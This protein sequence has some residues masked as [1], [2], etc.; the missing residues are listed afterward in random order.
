MEYL[1]K[2][3]FEK[4]HKCGKSSVLKFSLPQRTKL[5]KTKKS[6]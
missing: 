6:R 3:M 5:T 4:N 1:E 2:N